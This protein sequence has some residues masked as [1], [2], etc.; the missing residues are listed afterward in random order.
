MAEEFT[1]AKVTSDSQWMV[2]VDAVAAGYQ[3]L[4][5]YRHKDSKPLKALVDSHQ[6]MILLDSQ[7]FTD[8]FMLLLEKHECGFDT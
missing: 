7:T 4:N 1:Y 3:D 5:I 8:F 2:N 6:N